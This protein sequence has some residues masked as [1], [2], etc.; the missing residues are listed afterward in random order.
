MTAAAA[1]AVTVI[2]AILAAAAVA[3][4]VPVIVAVLAAS[5]A[6]AAATT[7]LSIG[8]FL[9]RGYMAKFEGHA[10]E[11]SYLFLEHFQFALGVHE[12]AGDRVIKQGVT[13]GFEG[14]DFRGSGL[15]TCMLF[16]MQ[17]F[18]EFMHGLIL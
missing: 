1:V 17:G 7:A 3:V 15:E 8:E 12:I 4:A 2:I 13:S 9:L 16:L 18:T 11:F 6:A 10:E 5:T 14:F